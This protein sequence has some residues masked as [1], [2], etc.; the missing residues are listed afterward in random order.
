MI[1]LLP[2][3]FFAH[4]S[5][6]NINMKVA[7]QRARTVHAWVWALPTE[8]LIITIIVRFYDDPVELQKKSS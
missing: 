2:L 6:Y 5:Y 1:L 7:L 4:F 8:P 3:F